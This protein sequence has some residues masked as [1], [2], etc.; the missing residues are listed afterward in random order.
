MFCII[1]CEV[2]SWVV[3]FEA[4]KSSVW[5]DCTVASWLVIAG[6][7]KEWAAVE[8]CSV[9]L[10]VGVITMFI[11]VELLV[12][13]FGLSVVLLISLSEVQ[14]ENFCWMVEFVDDCVTNDC[15]FVVGIAVVLVSSKLYGIN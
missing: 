5:V 1:P 8:C 3:M 2:A 9:K 7:A 13:T 12:S 11:V 15:W 4:V 14:V 10:D 6:P